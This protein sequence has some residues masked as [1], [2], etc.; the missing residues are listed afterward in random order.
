MVP[1]SIMKRLFW[2]IS[3]I[4]GHP[5][6]SARS[7]PP[8]ERHAARDGG[9][10][11]CSC[12][13]G[14]CLQVCAASV[15]ALARGPA[16]FR[17][18]GPVRRGGG[19]ASAA[20]PSFARPLR[21]AL[22]IRQGD[23]HAFQGRRC[24]AKVV[25]RVRHD[26]RGDAA[27]SC[28][29][30]AISRQQGARFAELIGGFGES[31]SCAHVV[32]RRVC[33]GVLPIFPASV[34]SASEAARCRSRWARPCTRPFGN[35]G[36]ASSLVRLLTRPARFGNRLARF[37]IVAEPYHARELSTRGAASSHVGL[38]R[39]QGRNRFAG[40]PVRAAAAPWRLD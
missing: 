22:C 40:S 2:S 27:G 6:K 5:A 23:G 31:V 24:A 8:C 1:A 38:T 9:A 13:I 20:G 34:A 26:G 36:G 10:C 16:R 15:S 21:R 14:V 37:S 32:V 4:D 39:P 28:Q 7:S 12:R 18:Q 30:C 17:E 35:P 3:L 11:L 29:Q 33:L 25:H 19:T